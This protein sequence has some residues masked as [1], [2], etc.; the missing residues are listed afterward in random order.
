MFAPGDF[1][2]LAEQL[3]GIKGKFV[4]SINDV[5]QV[6]ALFGGF[7]IEEVVTS[8]TVGKQAGSRGKRGELLVSM[9]V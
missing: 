5:P 6:R 1:D 7:D 3:G 4:M 8:Y 9:G 2:R